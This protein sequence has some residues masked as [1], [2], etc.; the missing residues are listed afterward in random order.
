MSGKGNI[1]LLKDALPELVQEMG[2][3]FTSRYDD[4]VHRKFYIMNFEWKYIDTDLHP[5]M[6]TLCIEKIL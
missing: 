5:G 4:I 6:V 2:Y 1:D 3:R